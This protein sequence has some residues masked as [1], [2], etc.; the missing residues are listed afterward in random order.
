MA[1]W[2]IPAAVIYLFSL[3]NYVYNIWYR[4]L[5]EFSGVHSLHVCVYVL[6]LAFSTNL[7]FDPKG[8]KNA[9]R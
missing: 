3:T 1:Q 4:G 6:V 5:R 8:L 7:Y 9:R 2:L